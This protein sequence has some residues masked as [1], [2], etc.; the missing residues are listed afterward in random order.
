MQHFSW[1]TYETDLRVIEGDE[2]HYLDDLKLVVDFQYEHPWDDNG[3][4]LGSCV[5]VHQLR[6]RTPDDKL[7]P[8]P[9]WLEKRLID[10][11][12]LETLSQYA[13]RS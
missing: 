3:E 9:E 1:R 4:Q 13:E 12:L 6:I 5:E 10:D 2:T 11:T 8:C 7:H